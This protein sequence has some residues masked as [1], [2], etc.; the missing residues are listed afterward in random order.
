MARKPIRNPMAYEIMS[1]LQKK[2]ITNN[3]DMQNGNNN[4]KH[5]T[6]I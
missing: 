3:I 6:A 5:E 1:F 4:I 2:I